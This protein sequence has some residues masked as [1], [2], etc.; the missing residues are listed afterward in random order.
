MEDNVEE[1]D[2]EMRDEVPDEESMDEEMIVEADENIIDD[3]ES[4]EVVKKNKSRPS[5]AK[6]KDHTINTTSKP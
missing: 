2:E 3:F 6:N 1:M 4:A 5:A